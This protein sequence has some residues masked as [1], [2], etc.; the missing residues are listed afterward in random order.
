MLLF[1]WFFP[2][3]SYRALEKYWMIRQMKR[4]VDVDKR[5]NVLLREGVRGT[6]FACLLSVPAILW[7]V[8]A[9]LSVVFRHDWV[10]WEL[11][12]IG[13]FP[14]CFAG[15]WWC[16][17]IGNFR[18]AR[19]CR[20]AEHQENQK[21]DKVIGR[22][23][24]E[25]GSR[26]AGSV[27]AD[28]VT[29]R[30]SPEPPPASQR[31][32]S[33]TMSN[34]MSN[35]IFQ[36]PH[37]AQRIKASSENVGANALCPTCGK[38]L[39]VPA[40]DLTEHRIEDA[41]PVRVSKVSEA[42]VLKLIEAADSD[43]RNN[44]QKQHTRQAKL[45]AINRTLVAV[46]Q[47]FS[48]YHENP[49]LHLEVQEIA[50]KWRRHVDMIAPSLGMRIVRAF[51]SLGKL[52]RHAKDPNKL[53]AIYLSWLFVHLILLVFSPKPLG[54]FSR[55]EGRDYGGFYPFLASEDSYGTALHPWTFEQ[56][57]ITEFAFYSLAPLVLWKVVRLWRTSEV[58]K[59]QEP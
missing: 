32:P 11:G 29:A 34:A 8:S 51:P 49:E 26:D 3:T 15:W 58:N 53:K 6:C 54:V 16:D 41:A 35:F 40:P 10:L 2:R 17:A 55:D 12:F 1:L 22:L 4:G 5:S 20:A 24:E 50:E 43:L 23:R 36:C 9:I 59:K 38:S 19:R 48:P 47:A 37:C 44:V 30:Q 57:D 31:S 52:R 18:S 45:A 13:I 27:G 7:V 46:K 28:F 39:A 56:Y 42:R 25:I 33:P 21:I 14:G